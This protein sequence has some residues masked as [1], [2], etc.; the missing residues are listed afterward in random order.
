MCPHCCQSCCCC[1]T[2]NC[3][4]PPECPIGP[5]NPVG[6]ISFVGNLHLPNL[7][8]HADIWNYGHPT[9]IM[10][11][12]VL[13]NLV[14]TADVRIIHNVTADLTLPNMVLSA[15][16]GN[17][18]T[19]TADLTLPNM[20]M[21]AS[22]TDATPSSPPAYVQ[23][24]QNYLN[25]IYTALTVTFTP[26]LVNHVGTGNFIIL[27]VTAFTTATATLSTP[28]GYTLLSSLSVTINP[29]YYG[30]QWIFMLPNANNATYSQPLT[31]DWTSSYNVYVHSNWGMTEFSGV[32]HVSPLDQSSSATG[33]SGSL[34]TGL[35]S[36]TTTASE[37]VV[38]VMS[39]I[40]G[41]GGPTGVA[42]GVAGPTYT[43]GAP[44]SYG[45]TWYLIQTSP[46]AQE[47]TATTSVGP[48]T[49]WIGTFLS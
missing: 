12:L 24:N 35:T 25:T 34:S 28:T 6:S 9:I 29:G 3:P 42:N 48:W 20:T 7:V 49:A 26:S 16:M 36:T 1:T 40:N 4:E 38:A 33:N 44:P 17:I 30:Y 8:M 32:A 11:P 18:K 22:V 23:N 46:S 37:L 13:P 27:T 19:A 2:V 10:A 5:V 45:T 14:M 47:C 39:L 15:S 21:A 43:E 41:A 31:L